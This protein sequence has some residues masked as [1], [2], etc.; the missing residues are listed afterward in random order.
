MD[1]VR[2]HLLLIDD[3]E[4]DRAIVRDALVQSDKIEYTFDEAETVEDG[5]A[6]LEAGGYDCALLDYSFPVGSALD[7]LRRAGELPVGNMIPVIMITGQGSEAVAVR[8]LRAG[9]HDYI[10]K[11]NLTQGRR[12]PGRVVERAIL[13]VKPSPRNFAASR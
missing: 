10:N 11:N 2:R 8:S 3:S 13:E 12:G 7:F 5:F 1:K 6:K 4:D 9:A